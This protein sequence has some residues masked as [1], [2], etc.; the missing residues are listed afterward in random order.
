M[1]CVR[2]KFCSRRYAWSQVAGVRRKGASRPAKERGRVLFLT[3]ER[4]ARCYNI[5][6]SGHILPAP[7]GRR[8]SEPRLVLTNRFF[9]T[10][11]ISPRTRTPVRRPGSAMVMPLLTHTRARSETLKRAP[12]LNGSISQVLILVMLTILTML[13]IGPRLNL[14]NSTN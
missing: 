14:N 9:M 2:V 10:G 11:K 3:N 5:K 13:E 6:R 1:C 4:Q 7:L 12:S 8:K